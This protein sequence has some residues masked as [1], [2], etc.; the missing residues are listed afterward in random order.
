[1]LKIS[2]DFVTREYNKD[3]SSQKLAKTAMYIVYSLTI[4]KL[5]LPNLMDKN[6][7]PL[8]DW[9]KEKPAPYIPSKKFHKYVEEATADTLVA[10]AKELLERFFKL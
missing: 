8:F 6:F 1:V 7:L 9:F 4:D 3:L 5:Y 2:Y 10:H